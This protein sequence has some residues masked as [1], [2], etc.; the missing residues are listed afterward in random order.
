MVQREALSHRLLAHR[1]HDLYRLREKVSALRII[2]QAD[3][4]HWTFV[5]I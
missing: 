2:V 5:A 1:R 4:E 3:D